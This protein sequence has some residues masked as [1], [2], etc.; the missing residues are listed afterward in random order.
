MNERRERGKGGLYNIWR[1]AGECGKGGWRERAIEMGPWVG[2]ESRVFFK[3]PAIARVA[4]GGLRYGPYGG[5]GNWQVTK[6]FCIF[7][8]FFSFF[9]I[10]CPKKLQDFEEK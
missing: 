1:R 4:L 2:N 9:N 3:Q 7:Q 5:G 8:R 10:F 6:F